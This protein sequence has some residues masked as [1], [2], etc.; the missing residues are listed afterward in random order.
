MP[1]GFSPK[2]SELVFSV[3]R[4]TVFPIPGSATVSAHLPSTS[5]AGEGRHGHR[6]GV[7][8]PACGALT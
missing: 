7:C 4:I 8:L 2:R 3:S 6:Q 1:W 5:R